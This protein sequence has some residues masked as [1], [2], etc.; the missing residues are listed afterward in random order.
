LNPLIGQSYLVP[1]KSG[2]QTNWV[3]QTGIDGLRL[4]AGRTREYAGSD[5]PVFVETDQKTT[6]GKTRPSKASVTVWRFVQGVRCPYTGSV[7]WEE[8]AQSS[9]TWNGMPHVMLAKCA[10]AHAL[11][12]AF[13]EDLS[14]LYVEE[15]MDQAGPVLNGEDQERAMR[16]VHAVA[17]EHGLDHDDLHNRA[18]QDHNVGSLKELTVGELDAM[19]DDLG[20][21]IDGETGELLLDGDG[22]SPLDELL[23]RTYAATSLDELEAIRKEK[24]DTGINDTELADAWRMRFRELGGKSKPVKIKQPALMGGVAGSA[25]ND[26][27]SD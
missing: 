9:S 20:D 18:V 27:Y 24:N 22:M 10:E 3:E 5:E 7:Y 19:A 1:R 25:G 13:P 6:A 15:E 4:I 2:G 17:R 21:I 11:R 16:R 14:G 8:Y 23:A 26:K 12:K